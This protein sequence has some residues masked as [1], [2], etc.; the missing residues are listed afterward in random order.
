MLNEDQVRENMRNYEQQIGMILDLAQVEF[1]YNSSWL[2]PLDR[3]PM[4]TGT[5]RW[6]RNRP[7]NW[8]NL[9]APSIV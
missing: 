2:K 9:P 7:T 5:P 3:W 8:V 1:Q 4:E 6:K